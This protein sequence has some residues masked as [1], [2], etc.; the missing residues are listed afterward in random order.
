MTASDPWLLFWLGCL[1]GG[2]AVALVS[3]AA[4][5]WRRPAYGWRR[6]R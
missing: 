6:D 1:S 3:W 4:A 5:L 2:C